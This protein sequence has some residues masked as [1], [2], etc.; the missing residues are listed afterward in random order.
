MSREPIQIFVATSIDCPQLSSLVGGRRRRGRKEK[1]DDQS[2]IIFFI[3][4]IPIYQAVDNSFRLIRTYME[5][6]QTRL[7]KLYTNK[8]SRTKHRLIAFV[9]ELFHPFLHWLSWGRTIYRCT[10][11]IQGRHPRKKVRNKFAFKEV[12][13]E[14]NFPLT[15]KI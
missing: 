4:S 7:I 1:N 9:F 3:P 12:R 15:V 5:R 14:N 13:G 11:Y 2:A 6:S 10:L 8:F